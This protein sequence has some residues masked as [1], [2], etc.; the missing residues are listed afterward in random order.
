VPHRDFYS[1]G[2]GF[3]VTAEE[4]EAPQATAAGEVVA[5]PYPFDGG[6]DAHGA[7]ERPFHS[8]YEAG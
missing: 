7:R 2:G 6:V 3:V 8:G 4:P 1:I 5:W